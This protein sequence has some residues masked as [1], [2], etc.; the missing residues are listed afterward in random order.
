MI[1]CPLLDIIML[2]SLI[3][4]GRRASSFHHVAFRGVM[5]TTDFTV[6]LRSLLC[7]VL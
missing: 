4:D 5:I 1:V 6:S 2:L 7:S 3:I